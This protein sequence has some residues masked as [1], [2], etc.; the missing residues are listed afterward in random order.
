MA[1]M[2]EPERVLAAP[3]ETAGLVEELELDLV[4]VPAGTVPLLDPVAV[5]VE[6]LAVAVAEG[7]IPFPAPSDGES[8]EPEETAPDELAT[9]TSDEPALADD[10]EADADD[11]EPP[12]PPETAIELEDDAVVELDPLL[13]ELEDPEEISLQERS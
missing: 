2:K 3:V 11:W 1:P 4:A 7:A 9:E 8:P 6:P 13:D 12:L 5:D 10:A